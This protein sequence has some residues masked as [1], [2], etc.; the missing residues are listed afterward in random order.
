MNKLMAHL[1]FINTR[2]TQGHRQQIFRGHLNWTKGKKRITSGISKTEIWNYCSILKQCNRSVLISVLC[3][4]QRMAPVSHCKNTTVFKPQQWKRT[5]PT[6]GPRHHSDG[7]GGGGGGG[8]GE[9]KKME[10]EKWEEEEEDDKIRRNN[11]QVRR[12]KI[13][14]RFSK[15]KNV[16]N[17][18]LKENMNMF[19]TTVVVVVDR[20]E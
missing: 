5:W 7:G 19:K 16:C 11:I 9:G 14:K 17:I 1:K 15:W 8:G 6:N 3:S 10:E 2:R 20:K 4:S 18:W 12:K 13:P